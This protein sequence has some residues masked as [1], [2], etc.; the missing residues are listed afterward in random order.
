MN[1]IT[2]Q[3]RQEIIDYFAANEILWSGKLED[4]VFL[5]K[6]YDLS[7]LPS[8]DSRYRNASEDIWK[9]RVAN[10]DW[11]NEW[12]F[13]D[14]RFNLINTPD[15]EFIVLQALQHLQKPSRI[16]NNQVL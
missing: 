16:L 5:A 15:N 11:D 12:V 14:S 2:P 6:L 3:L 7:S 4:Q 13:S 8:K 10:D 9:H 1:K